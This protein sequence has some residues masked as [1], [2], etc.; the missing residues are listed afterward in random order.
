MRFRLLA[1]IILPSLLLLCS[2]CCEPDCGDR[3]CGD[4]GCG[5]T[6]KNTCESLGT[7]YFCNPSSCLCETC[8]GC[9]SDDDCEM[10]EYCIPEECRC[11]LR[12]SYCQQYGSECKTDADCP[13]GEHCAVRYPDCVCEIDCGEP[14]GNSCPPGCQD[15]RGITY[16]YTCDCGYPRLPDTLFCRSSDKQC[17]GSSQLV[18]SP[19][20]R[21]YILEQGCGNKLPSGWLSGCCDLPDSPAPYVVE[22][23]GCTSDADCMTAELCDQRCSTCVYPVGCNLAPAQEMTVPCGGDSCVVG[24]C[25]EPV[26]WDENGRVCILPWWTVGLEEGDS[27]LN[28][29]Y[30]QM[31]YSS[32]MEIVDSLGICS[33]A[34]QLIDVKSLP[35]SGYIG[36]APP[37]DVCLYPLE[38]ESEKCGLATTFCCTEQSAGGITSCR[39]YDEVL[40]ARNGVTVDIDNRTCTLP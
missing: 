11:A 29:K 37:S 25:A 39:T 14:E 33:L 12:D 40:P 32:W 26:P 8:V 24:P 28:Y 38:C 20:G 19:S 1:F 17:T 6:C 27:G 34:S 7:T 10:D 23:E 4:D 35:A 31:T 22:C 13:E 15:V 21:C 5:G 16:V 18:Q 36:E 30:N 9:T 2:G 3:C